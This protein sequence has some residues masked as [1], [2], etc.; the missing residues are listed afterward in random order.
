MFILQ[1]LSRER[2]FT[3]SMKESRE[4]CPNVKAAIDTLMILKDLNCTNT[5]VKSC[6]TP[7]TC[8]IVILKVDFEP[9]MRCGPGWVGE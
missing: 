3:P 7:M 4:I 6:G 1:G 2:H 5:S 9:S 8:S